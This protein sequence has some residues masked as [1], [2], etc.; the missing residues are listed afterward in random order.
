[1]S[2]FD[3]INDSLVGSYGICIL[4]E[5]DQFKDINFK[6]ASNVLVEP[7][8]FIDGRNIINI[9]LVDGLFRHVMTLDS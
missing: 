3:S 9:N 5:W 2:K 8:L 6:K 7:I 1:M 4:T